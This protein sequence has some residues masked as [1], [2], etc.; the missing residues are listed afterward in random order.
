MHVLAV[1]SDGKWADV[2]ERETVVGDGERS[3]WCNAVIYFGA[4]KNHYSNQWKKGRIEDSD[5][6]KPLVQYL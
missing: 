3:M 6:S 1:G 4:S 2:E 5:K